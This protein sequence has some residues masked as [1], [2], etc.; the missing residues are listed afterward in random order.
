[1]KAG[2]ELLLPHDM[3]KSGKNIERLSAA[4]KNSKG[5]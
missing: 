4:M 5:V 1:L 3:Y 2:S